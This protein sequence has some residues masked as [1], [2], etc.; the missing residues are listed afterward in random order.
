MNGAGERMNEA[1]QKYKGGEAQKAVDDLCSFFHVEPEVAHG[2]LQR[3]GVFFE[4]GGVSF[5]P[6][7]GAGLFVEASELYSGGHEV[8]VNIRFPRG[9][10]LTVRFTHVHW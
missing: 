4:K 2:M 1:V 3:L 7:N 5:V 9:N 8:S 6:V 10:E